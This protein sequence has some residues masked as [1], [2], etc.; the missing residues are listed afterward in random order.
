MTHGTYLISENENNYCFLTNI[1]SRE[2][3]TFFWNL[4]GKIKKMDIASGMKPVVRIYNR[5]KL[6]SADNFNVFFY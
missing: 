3:F 1:R 6:D 2:N 4:V 5:V